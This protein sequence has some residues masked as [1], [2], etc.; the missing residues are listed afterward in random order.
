MLTTPHIIGFVFLGFCIL[1]HGFILIKQLKRLAL[2]RRQAKTYIGDDVSI[3]HD[4]GAKYAYRGIC[5]YLGGDYVESL[6]NLK[7]ALEYS[8]VS[9]N[10]AFCLDWMSQ[11][12]ESLDK[13]MESLHCCVKAVQ[14]EP[15]NIKS[16]FNLADI[17][18]KQGLFEKAEFYYN[19]ILHYDKNNAPAK[20]MIGTLYMGLGEYRNAEEQFL[21]ILETDNRFTSAFA[22]LSVINAI[23]G[24]YFEMDNYYERAKNNRY[25]ESVRLRKRLDSIK[26]IQGMCNVL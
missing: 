20:F 1:V 19:Q 3:R 5:A 8:T 2:N 23:K 7:K 22:E 13:P 21:E 10:N 4:E 15:S 6:V 14:A 24:D 16:L 11:C 9:H 26:K 25:V 17:Y 12:Y 18:V